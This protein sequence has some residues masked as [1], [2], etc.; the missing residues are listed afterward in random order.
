VV[1]TQPSGLDR[2]VIP[3]AQRR[4]VDVAAEVAKED[5]VVVL[6]AISTPS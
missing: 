2:G 4:A 3:A 1:W 5:Q 6:G